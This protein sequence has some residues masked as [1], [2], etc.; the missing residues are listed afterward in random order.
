[1]EL[2]SNYGFETVKTKKD[3]KEKKRKKETVGLNTHISRVWT[4]TNKKIENIMIEWWMG[5]SEWYWDGT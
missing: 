1:M 4:E 3:E 2:R 5:Q